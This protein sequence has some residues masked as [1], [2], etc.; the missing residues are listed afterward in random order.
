MGACTKNVGQ[1][2]IDEYLKL[3]IV[4]FMFHI[5]VNIATDHVIQIQ[6]RSRL[7]FHN[8]YLFLK[9]IDQL[10]TGP[11]WI[12]QTVEVTTLLDLL[13]PP[14]DHG[15]SSL[16]HYVIPILP[17]TSSLIEIAFHQRRKG[18]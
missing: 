16:L 9:K 4:S 14:S 18:Y 15:N 11:N 13:P 3:P 5:Q 8:P 17:N 12:G 7:S 6:E 2:S 1:K 10:P